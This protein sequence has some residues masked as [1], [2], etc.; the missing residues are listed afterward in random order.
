MITNMITNSIR[1]NA[2]I[3]M[4][5][6]LFIKARTLMVATGTTIS[7]FVH[8]VVMVRT[9]AANVIDSTNT[10]VIIFLEHQ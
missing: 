7:T 4:L 6:V 2:A 3:I 1:M 5:T 8:V 10:A 9:P